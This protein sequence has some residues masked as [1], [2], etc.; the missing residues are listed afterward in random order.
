MC[1]TEMGN[2]FLPIRYGQKR[3]HI[4]IYYIW[5]SVQYYLVQFSWNLQYRSF[6]IR[7]F[8]ILPTSVDHHCFCMYTLLLFTKHTI[9]FEW[10]MT[11][12]L[13][14]WPVLLSS[15]FKNAERE[16]KLFY[17]ELRR[18]FGLLTSLVVLRAHHHSTRKTLPSKQTDGR[19][20]IVDK[21][22]KK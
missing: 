20:R 1:K 10:Y 13:N 12:V 4:F 6:G 19:D 14:C 22:L 7:Y 15:A 16:K 11:V 3:V 2:E 18:L 21:L 9:Q 5:D 8:G 17:L